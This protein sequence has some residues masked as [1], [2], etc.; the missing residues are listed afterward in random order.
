MEQFYAALAHSRVA[1]FFLTAVACLTLSF[2]SNATCDN[3]TNGGTI[4]GA[5]AGCY[6]FNPSVIT[7][8]SSPSGG[9]GALEIIWMYWNASTNWNMT[10]VSGATGLTYDPGV[11]FEDTYFRRCSRRANCSSYDG[12]SNDIF[13]DI[14]SCVTCSNLTSG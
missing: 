12:E 8:E 11:I 10:T 6:G 13:I 1:K 7:N 14:T 5:Q 9:S 2:A 4:G 3:V